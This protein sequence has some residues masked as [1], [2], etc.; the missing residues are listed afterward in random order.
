M[1]KRDFARLIIVDDFLNEARSTTY[2]LS[3]IERITLPYKLDCATLL[4]KPRTWPFGNELSRDTG[5]SSGT[6]IPANAT[7][8]SRIVTRYRNQKDIRTTHAR[9]PS[10][11]A[12]GSPYF[13]VRK[14]S[15]VLWTLRQSL[16]E[17]IS[18]RRHRTRHRPYD[19][20]IDHDWKRTR[21]REFVHEGRRQMLASAHQMVRL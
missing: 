14:R 13:I 1:S 5:L 11:H 6:L 3:P 4:R 7:Q 20:S 19:L 8:R 10:C 2:Q 15:L 16:P 18:R 9:T 17:R 21:L 12:A